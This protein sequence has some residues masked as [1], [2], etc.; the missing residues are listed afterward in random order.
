[1]GQHAGA[2]QDM[3][4]CSDRVQ[5][6]ALKKVGVYSITDAH[7]EGKPGLAVFGA[8]TKG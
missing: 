4:H 2:S 3:V 5:A 7:S 8:E 6:Y 1:M